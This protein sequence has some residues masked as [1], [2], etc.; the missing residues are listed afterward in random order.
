MKRLVSAIAVL[1]AVISP[2]PAQTLESSR[3]D[4]GTP[5]RWAFGVSLLGL[6]PQGEFAENV[7]FAGGLGGS[8]LYRLDQ[9]GIV[10]FRAE[11]GFL[12]Y[13][14][15]RYRTPLGGGPLGLIR[16]DVNTTNSIVAGGVGLQLMTPGTGVRPYAL[17][18]GGFSHFFTSSSVEGRDNTEPFA[19]STNYEDGGLAWTW[20]GGLYV[21]LSSRGNPVNL[22]L[23]IRWIDNGSR[24]Y[25]RDDGITFEGGGV[26][27]HPVRSEAKGLQFNLGLTV[28]FR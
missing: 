8:A 23:G 18:T 12:V 21:P 1:A 7:D 14:H 15:E 24:E 17:A 13:G 19:S 6:A 9:R 2:V 25:L 3:P 22:D 11:L 10:A 4:D 16:V 5:S 28:P 26:Q 27:L 20:G